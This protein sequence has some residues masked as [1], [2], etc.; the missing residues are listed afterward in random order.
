MLEGKINFYASEDTS[1]NKPHFKGF[2]DIGGKVHEFAVWPAKNGKGWSGRYKEKAPLVAK[3][4]P[5]EAADE[6]LPF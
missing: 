3:E 5:K 4:P 2:I 1:N 6:P